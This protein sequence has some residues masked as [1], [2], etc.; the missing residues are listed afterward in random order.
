MLLVTT[1]LSLL[2]RAGWR[3]AR[4]TLGGAWV[5]L[6]RLQRSILTAALGVLICSG[7]RLRLL[8]C[9]L[10]RPR[11]LRH[12]VHLAIGPRV[13]TYLQLP[14]VRVG[15]HAWGRRARGMD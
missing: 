12:L 14:V 6:Y 4:A 8:R 5:W 7:C 9:L 10:L 13:P 11:L 15:M 1:A 2:C 3:L